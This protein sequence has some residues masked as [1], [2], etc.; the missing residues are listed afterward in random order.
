MLTPEAQSGILRFVGTDGAQHTVNVL[1][2]AGAAGY[3]TAVDPI[4]ADVL[5]V[6]NGTVSQGTVLPSSSNLYQQSL[7][8]KINTGS[9]DIYPTAR[10]DYQ[11]TK[12]LAWHGT[13]NLQHNHV[14]P[15]GSSY[16][17]IP[18]QA[19][20]S[21]FTRY[22][23]SNGVDWTIAPRIFNSVKFGLQSSVSGVTSAIRYT[24]GKRRTTSASASAWGLPP[25]FPTP[26]R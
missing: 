20:E 17:G 2:L 13:W 1:Q 12:S 5:Q 23:L 8:W 6:I 19:G 24:S 4:V 7:N 11:I 9:R 10:L 15:T 21:K 25:S 22:A 14:D 16:P 18:G 26:H 3:R